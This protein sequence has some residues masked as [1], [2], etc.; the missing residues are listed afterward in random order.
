MF[1]FKEPGP[2]TEE[3]SFSSASSPSVIIIWTSKMVVG[4]TEEEETHGEYKKNIHFIAG[5]D[6]EEL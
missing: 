4:V 1:S 6:T 3:A 5:A 2:H